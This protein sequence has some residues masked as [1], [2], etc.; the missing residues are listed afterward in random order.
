MSVYKLDFNKANN[1]MRSIV[2]PKCLL[3][4]QIIIWTFNLLFL[5]ETQIRTI[6]TVVVRKFVSLGYYRMRNRSSATITLALDR[7]LMRY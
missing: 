4:V 7:F 2:T 1:G 5:T 3:T 6:K